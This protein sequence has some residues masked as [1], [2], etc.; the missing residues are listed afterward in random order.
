MKRTLAYT[1]LDNAL[2]HFRNQVSECLPYAIDD[3]PKF[4]SPEKIFNWLKLR[5]QYK[6]DPQ[7]V[8]LFQTIDTLLNDNVHGMSGWGDC[9]CFSIAGL[10]MLL[11]NGF[12]DCG[13]VL[14]GRTKLFPVHIYLYVKYDNKKEYFDLT[15]KI[16]NFERDYKY[17]Q[18]IP[19]ILNQ[20]EKNMILQLA[21]NSSFSQPLGYLFLSSE[22]VNVREDYFDNLSCGQFQRKMLSEGFNEQQL[23]ELSNNRANRKANRQSGELKPRQQRKVA[24]KEAKPRNQRKMIKTQSKADKR[25]ATGQAKII[26]STG[27]SEKKINNSQA[28][29][30]KA[31]TQPQF[32]PSDSNENDNSINWMDVVNA[33]NS[34]LP[35]VPNEDVEMVEVEVIENEDAEPMEE[36]YSVTNTIICLGLLFAGAY[37]EKKF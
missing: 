32:I 11:A 33:S 36:G 35:E 22:G 21:E 37:I 1:N 9:D 20:N 12:V 26:R 3:L 16:Y 23:L 29:L 28:K 2:K 5:T 25:E 27:R 18:E 8:E 15:N 24:K 14:V 19:Y 7:G 17:R 6:N 4:D 13:I 30:V 10:T 34:G 31:Q